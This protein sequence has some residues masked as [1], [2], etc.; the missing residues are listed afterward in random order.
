[1]VGLNPNLDVVVDNPF[2]RDQNLHGSISP[3]LM[4]MEINSPIHQRTEL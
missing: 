4:N 2:D 1:L 3:Q